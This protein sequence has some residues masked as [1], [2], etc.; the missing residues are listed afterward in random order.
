MIIGALI[1]VAWDTGGNIFTDAL[2]RLWKRPDGS[3]LLIADYPDLYAV[4]GTRYG[5]ATA[6][7]FKLP[8]FTTRFVRGWDPAASID[9]DAASR[10]IPGPGATSADAGTVQP[11]IVRTHS[12]YGFDAGRFVRTDIPGTWAD[13]GAVNVYGSGP[14]FPSPTTATTISGYTTNRVNYTPDGFKPYHM[15]VDFL[16]RIK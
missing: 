7:D 16:I 1:T 8:N 10:T 13:P 2:G 15:V 5:S 14:N 4:I 12:H 9:V 6:L 3:S 11:E